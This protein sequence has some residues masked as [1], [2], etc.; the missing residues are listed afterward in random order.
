MRPCS[1]YFVRSTATELDEAQSRLDDDP[2]F[3]N[4]FSFAKCLATSDDP[5]N[6]A[7][8]IAYIESLLG[9]QKSLE[10]DTE[11]RELR[12]FAF[13]R[14]KHDS[15]CKKAIDSAKATKHNSKIIP[16]IEEYYKNELIT[17]ISVGVGIGSVVVGAAAFLLG[18]IF[19]RKKRN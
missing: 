3:E 11:L 12:I 9:T 7:K 1:P 4:M 19:S 17:D 15:D 10:K 13:Y 8:S 18:A 6:V 14:L 2:S 5:A 16:S